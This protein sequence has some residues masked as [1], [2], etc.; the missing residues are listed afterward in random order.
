MFRLSDFAI[1]DCLHQAA[2]PRGNRIG[3]RRGRFLKGPVPLEWLIEAAKL[4]GKSLHVGVVLWFL[5]G[6][7]KSR[8]V[9]F[10]PSRRREFGI[11]RHASYRALK[12]LEMAGLVRLKRKRGRAPLV[13]IVEAERGD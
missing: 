6:L 8:E 10:A 3:V 5:S 13:T 12:C 9:T 1:E 2:R 11:G 7:K 4:P